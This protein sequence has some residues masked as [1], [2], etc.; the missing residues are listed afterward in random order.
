M[1]WMKFSL[2]TF[3]K[4][5]PDVSFQLLSVKDDRSIFAAISRNDSLLILYH[6]KDPNKL[7]LKSFA[8]QGS[9]LS[10]FPDKHIIS[11]IIAYQ[12]EAKIHKS[13]FFNCTLFGLVLRYLFS[14]L[15][16]SE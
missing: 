6:Q 3:E 8:E 15:V 2:S 9:Y 13:A 5:S 10:C 1:N 14:L 7:K 16:Y 11:G 4:S 12:L